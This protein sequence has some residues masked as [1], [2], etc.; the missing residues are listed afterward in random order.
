[1]RFQSFDR[2]SF[3]NIEEESKV[4]AESRKETP[5]AVFLYYSTTDIKVTTTSKLITLS[6]FISSIGGNLG[7]FIGFS[8]IRMFFVVY[9]YL[10]RFLHPRTQDNII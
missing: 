1:M 10:A 2:R 8:F 7:L 5:R 3:I 4:K 6:S 9:E